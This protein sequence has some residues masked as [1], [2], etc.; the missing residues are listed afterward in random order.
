MTAPT[1]DERWLVVMERAYRGAVESQYAD[2]LNFVQDL[3]RQSGACDLA[4]RGTAVG[5]AVRTGFEPSVRIGSRTLDTLPDPR[6]AL[7][8]MLA[9]GMTVLV[10]EDG[11]ASLGRTAR[12][13]LLPGVRVVGGGELAA[14]W[15]SY[16]QVWFM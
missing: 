6:A 13:R 4:L 12:E 11:L 15:P 14:S 1:P 2:G 3:H 10:E 8:R 7:T 5:Y 16:T 9:D